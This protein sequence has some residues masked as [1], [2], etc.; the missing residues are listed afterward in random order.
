ME[1]TMTIMALEIPDDLALWS[2][3]FRLDGVHVVGVIATG[4]ATITLLQIN[5]PDCLRERQ[6]LLRRRGGAA[7]TSIN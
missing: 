5:R 4:R 7:P 3:H 6:H 2:E 1:L